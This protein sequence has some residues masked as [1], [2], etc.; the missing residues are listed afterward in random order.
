[1]GKKQ[2]DRLRMNS[3]QH[4]RILLTGLL[5]GMLGFVPVFWRLYPDEWVSEPFPLCWT[6][7][8]T[9]SAA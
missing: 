3:G 6:R 9:A 5:L 1:M 8:A 4:R 7:R 2:Y